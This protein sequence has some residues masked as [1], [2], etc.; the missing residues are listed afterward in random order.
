MKYLVLILLLVAC[1]KN[2]E[3]PPLPSMPERVEALNATLK[4][5]LY[6][7]AWLSTDCDSALWNGL[8]VY[9]GVEDIDIFQAEYESG[10]WHR[11]PPPPCYVAER[12][13]GEPQESN[14]TISN[15]MFAGIFLALWKL[16]DLDAV[17]RIYEY[18][19]ANDWVM[20]APYPQE[21]SR[22]V[23]RNGRYYVARMIELLGG[24]KHTEQLVVPPI[25][26][27]AGKDYEQHLQVISI[28]LYGELNGNIND[29]MLARL[30]ECSEQNPE[31]ALFEAVYTIYH[32][33]DY[34]RAMNLILNENYELPSYVRGDEVY[35]KIHKLL[36]T[37]IILQKTGSEGRVL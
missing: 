33:G 35:D 9:S 22:V 2:K 12:P 20:G 25:Y 24:P 37:E 29:Q 23:L 15:D 19:I 17:E 26:I 7:E 31:D 14:S 16:Q 27:E 11:R 3:K 1:G 30:K 28:K 4:A 32:T 10:E 34:T 13:D 21:F 36:V 6:G 8:A 18:G 5:E